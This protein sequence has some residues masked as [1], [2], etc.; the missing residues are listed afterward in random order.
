MNEKNEKANYF[1]MPFNM[2][3]PQVYKKFTYI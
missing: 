2:K 3:L 1:A